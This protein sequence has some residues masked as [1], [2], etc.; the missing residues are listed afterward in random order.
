[1]EAQVPSVLL[2]RGEPFRTSES[3]LTWD[4]GCSSVGRGLAKHAVLGS[5]PSTL[6]T[7]Q[8]AEQDSKTILLSHITSLR[9]VWAIGNTVKKESQRSNSAELAHFSRT[10]WLFSCHDRNVLRAYVSH[11]N[12]L[13][14][15]CSQAAEWRPEQLGFGT[16][17]S[18]GS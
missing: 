16:C 18:Q 14:S 8:Q 5:T 4:E 13:A 15:S 17:S 2:T 12:L 7:R 9:P 3:V 6:C 11:K 1:M 10:F